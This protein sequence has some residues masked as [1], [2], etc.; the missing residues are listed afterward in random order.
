MAYGVVGVEYDE[1]LGQF[2]ERGQILAAYPND[3][4]TTGDIAT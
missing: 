2:L 4:V 1:D 3:A